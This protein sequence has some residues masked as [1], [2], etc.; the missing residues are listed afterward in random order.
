MKQ[1]EKLDLQLLINEGDDFPFRFSLANQIEESK[2]SEAL[3]EYVRKQIL[4]L[5]DVAYL[6]YKGERVR[7]DG[8]QF[9]NDPDKIWNLFRTI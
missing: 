1:S 3:N 6:C 7:I 4:S 9:H 8:F 5:L 2:P